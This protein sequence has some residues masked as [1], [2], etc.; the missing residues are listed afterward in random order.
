[1]FIKLTRKDG[2]PIW[3]NASFVVTVEPL[4]G[5]GSVVVPIGDGLD[6]D[7]RETPEAV[8]ALLDGAPAPAVVPVPSSDAL[9]AMPDDVSPVATAE[10]AVAES[11]P[12]SE[13]E[14]KPAKRTRKAK[15]AVGGAAVPAKKP[16]KPRARGRKP[17]LTLSEDEIGRLRKLAPKT[18]KK[19]ANTLTAQFKVEDV[20]VTVRALEA[21]GIVELDQERVKWVGLEA[22]EASP[23]APVEEAY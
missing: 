3:L 15:A 17:A 13:S 16:A 21:H 5:G 2:S 11:E 18:V 23:A 14:A 22:A 12:E 19:L 1:M 7:V 9:T 20:E 8:L 4:R 10:E 6:Y